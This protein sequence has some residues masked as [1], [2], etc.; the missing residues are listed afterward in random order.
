[1]K[2][3]P[4]LRRQLELE[5]AAALLAKA[6]ALAVIYLAFFSGSPAVP[7]A[8]RWLFGGAR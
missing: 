1:M 5:I 2:K 6:C 3:S 8:A 7:T 4:R